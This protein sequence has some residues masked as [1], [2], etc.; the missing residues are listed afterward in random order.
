MEAS[1]DPVVV[2]GLCATAVKFA[3]KNRALKAVIFANRFI[4]PSSIFF[5]SFTR[6]QALPKHLFFYLRRGTGYLSCVDRV[7]NSLH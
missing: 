2:V 5:V 1:V 3:S 6:G 7:E 4:A